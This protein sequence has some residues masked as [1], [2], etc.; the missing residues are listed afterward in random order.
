MQGEETETLISELARISG[1]E[2]ALI[3][4][5]GDLLS[6]TYTSQVC[7]YLSWIILCFGICVSGLCITTANMK[8]VIVGASLKKVF[9]GWF[10]KFSRL[11][12]NL[13]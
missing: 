8:W 2:K 10:F 11:V 13:I 5:C 7:F 6:N 12:C 4:E 3:E 9:F 1:G